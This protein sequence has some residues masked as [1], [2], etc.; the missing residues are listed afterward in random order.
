M[1]S[2]DSVFCRMLARAVEREGVSWVRLVKISQVRF[3][4]KETEPEAIRLRTASVFV[5]CQVHSV[6]KFQCTASA[7][8]A[9][10]TSSRGYAAPVFEY[11]VVNLLWPCGPPLRMKMGDPRGRLASEPRTGC[12]PVIQRCQR[13]VKLALRTP[14]GEEDQL[15]CWT[16]KYFRGKDRLRQKCTRAK[17]SCCRL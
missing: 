5:R 3:A 1:T 2:G 9:E 10:K 12:E 4:K 14:C 8:P 6:W 13:T 7:L 16:R 17:C 11:S 15:L